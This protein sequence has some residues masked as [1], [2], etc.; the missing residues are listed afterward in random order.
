MVVKAKEDHQRQ[1]GD[2]FCPEIKETYKD[3]Q[4][5]KE[6][7]VH[8]KVGGRAD[9]EK[10]GV[11]GETAPTGKQDSPEGGV[12]LELELDSGTIGQAE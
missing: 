10:A 5:K 9:V 2:T 8:E 12:K 1:G 11:E 4:G 7:K 3:Q 6:I